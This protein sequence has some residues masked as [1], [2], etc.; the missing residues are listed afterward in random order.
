MHGVISVK[1]LGENIS[2][3]KS[4]VDFNTIDD[5][6][7][8]TYCVNDVTILEKFVTE[9]IRFLITNNLGSFKTTIASQALTAY[10]TRFMTKAPVIHSHNNALLMERA[11]YSGGRTEAFYLGKLNTSK[12]YY[13]DINSMYP[14]VMK[15]YRYP[16]Y[17]LGYSVNVPISHLEARLTCYYCIAHVRV[18]TRI[19]VYP[20]KQAI[21]SL[22]GTGTNKRE[23]TYRVESHLGKLTFPIGEFDT[24]L[25]TEELAYA[26]QHNHITKIYSCCTYEQDY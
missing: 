2:H 11:A 16:T 20:V 1:M 6:T 3:L 8:M 5:V 22:S 12:Y 10:R 13:I 15:Y 25:H 7:L 9:Y 14:Y 21:K 19:P 24:Y 18:S 26:L 4:S 17:F 23:I